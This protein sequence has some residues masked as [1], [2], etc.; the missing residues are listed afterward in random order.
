MKS[1]GAILI[2][3]ACLV[4]AYLMGNSILQGLATEKWPTVVGH[5]VRI[6]K[7]HIGSVTS[8]DVFLP[9][10]TYTYKV[11]GLDVTS[12]R[13][14]SEPEAIT[15][16]FSYF[17]LSYNPAV[18]ETGKP[19]IVHYNPEAPGEAVI[20]TGVSSPAWVALGLSVVVLVLTILSLIQKPGRPVEV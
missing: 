3:S 11:E 17:G 19:V 9:E 20:K 1:I 6:D 13:L 15:E 12:N 14:S 7:H 8:E 10:V 18:Y 5:I 2:C 4:V 16:F